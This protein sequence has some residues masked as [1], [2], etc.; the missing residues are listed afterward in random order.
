MLGGAARVAAGGVATEGPFASEATATH[1]RVHRIHGYPTKVA[2]Y[3]SYSC[4]GVLSVAALSESCHLGGRAIN[5]RVLEQL[6]LG[7]RQTTGACTQY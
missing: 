3:T 7:L 1:N 5:G 4:R 6:T 2:L